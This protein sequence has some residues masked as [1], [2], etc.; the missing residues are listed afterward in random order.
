MMRHACTTCYRL[1]HL[2]ARAVSFSSRREV[3][4]QGGGEGVCSG[5][6]CQY[7]GWAHWGISARKPL[8]GCPR[9]QS[10]AA[11]MEVRGESALTASVVPSEVPVVRILTSTRHPSSNGCP[12]DANNQNC[13]VKGAAKASTLFTGA[14]ACLT[15][16]SGLHAHLSLQRTPSG[17]PAALSP[18]PCP[19]REGKSGNVAARND[20]PPAHC[21]G[22][23]DAAVGFR[24]ANA[25]RPAPCTVGTLEA[26]LR[27]LRLPGTLPLAFWIRAAWLY[28]P[29]AP[30]GVTLPSTGASIPPSR[31]SVGRS[32]PQFAAALV[33]SSE[34]N[35]RGRARPRHTE[36]AAFL[37]TGG[38]HISGGRGGAG[39]RRL[40]YTNPAQLPEYHGVL[41]LHALMKV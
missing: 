32:A 10:S 33:H 14:G 8:P 19:A 40:S 23:D 13:A 26:P 17:D 6:E 28:P 18:S 27:P 21:H 3:V 12:A 4:L 39:R 37:S 11:G 41:Q 31:R 5:G 1:P 2:H 20:R 7:V 9:G 15:P 36:Q 34:D 25:A 35:A 30:P 24:E 38:A 16:D 29:G 22:L